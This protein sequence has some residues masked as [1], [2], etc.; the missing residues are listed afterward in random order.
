MPPSRRAGLALAGTLVPASWILATPGL[1]F[2]AGGGEAGSQ[3]TPVA[4]VA[5]LLGIGSAYLLAN[6]VVDRLQRRALIIS[7]V[8]YILVGLLLGPAVPEVDVLTD[9]TG[10][11]PAIALAAGWIGLLRGMGLDGERL[12]NRLPGSLRIAVWHHAIPGT[13]VGYVAYLFFFRGIGNIDALLVEPALGVFDSTWRDAAASGFFLGCAA[14]SDSSEPFTVIERRYEI[15]GTITSH[16]RE[17]AR[18]GDVLVILAFGLVFC[19]FHLPDPERVAAGAPELDWNDWFLLQTG[20]G[21]VLG[22][23]FSPFLGGQ[24]SPNG[25]FLALV[26]IIAFASGAAYFLA[27]SPLAVNAVVGLVLAS[28]A[29]SGKRIRETLTTTEKPMALVLLVLA[30]FLW[31]APPWAPTLALLLV[32]I[33]LRLIGKILA[34]RAAVLGLDLRRDLWKGLLAH[35]DVTVAMAISFKVV[36]EGTAVNV[37]YTVVLASVVLHDLVAPRILRSLLVDAGDVKRERSEA[38]TLPARPRPAAREDH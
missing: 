12:M 17:S 34:S 16:L 13:I 29:R 8:E 15:E 19:I 14:A 26:G 25:V 24:E 22:F 10:L 1:A 4:L 21:L 2:A 18:I 31:E 20:L 36:F 38:S 33:V 9:V 27:L 28:S 6:F 7:G 23:L 11:L 30:G 35:G 3:G 37:A 32:F 5:V